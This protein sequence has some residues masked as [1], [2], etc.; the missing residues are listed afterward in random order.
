VEVRLPGVSRDARGRAARL[1]SA[2]RVT[3]VRLRPVSLIH[4]EQ[5]GS[6]NIK[7]FCPVDERSLKKLERCKAAGDA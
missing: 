2:K 5:G 4:S 1:A 7:T 3:A 6:M